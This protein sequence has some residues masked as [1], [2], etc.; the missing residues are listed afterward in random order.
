MQIQWN[1][2]TK[3]TSHVSLNN[4]LSQTILVA[5]SWSKKWRI[6]LEHLPRWTLDWASRRLWGTDVGLPDN[7]ASARTWNADFRSCQIREISCP[8]LKIDG[9]FFKLWQNHYNYK[10][11]F[12]EHTNIRT[13]RT[14]RP[15]QSGLYWTLLHYKNV[16]IPFVSRLDCYYYYVFC[17]TY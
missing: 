4:L 11:I 1:D 13:I 7:W 5:F 14:I 10:D 12:F 15:L 6:D 3:K 9:F 8:I 2:Q 16:I 17:L